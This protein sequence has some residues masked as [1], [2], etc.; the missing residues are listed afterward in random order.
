MKVRTS[1]PRILPPAVLDSTRREFLFGAGSLLVLGGGTLAGCGG[2]AGGSSGGDTVRIEHFGGTTEVP[3]NVE[4]IAALDSYPDMHSLFALGVPP[5]IAPTE[6]QENIPL[7][8]E[9]LDDVEVSIPRSEP[10]FEMLA[11]EAPDLIF[12]VEYGEEY[13]ERLSEIAPTVLLHRYEQNVDEHL[14]T[15]ARAV[16]RPEEAE[17]V[18]REFEERVSE[19]GE[20]VGN[21]ALS[22]AP[23]A[24]ILDF[25]YEGTFRVLGDSSYCGR[26]L[27][28]VGANG[29]INPDGEPDGPD[30]EFGVNVSTELVAEVLEEA[31]FI[32]VGT[33]DIY[34][35]ADRLRASELWKRLPAVENGAIFETPVDVWYQDTAL[36][37]L[38]RLADIEELVRR[39]G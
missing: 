32:V 12:H 25:A 16:G 1:S 37:R 28:A 8:G 17:R 6:G 7:V 19:V 34:E 20:R 22:D 38:A 35:G 14:A 33:Y 11:A 21:S 13:Y 36:T 39:F 18:I 27:E 24:V 2:R 30:A 4:R 29:L 3:R 9:R 15:V 26:T 23:F 31:E 10:N 5:A